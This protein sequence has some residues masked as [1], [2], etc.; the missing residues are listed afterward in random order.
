MGTSSPSARC[1]SRANRLGMRR[2]STWRRQRPSRPVY[3]QN[4]GGLPAWRVQARQRR[5]VQAWR[6]K[7]NNTWVGQTSQY[8]WAVY[9]L[10]ARPSRRTPGPPIKEMLW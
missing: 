10:T 9:S 4:W 6:L 7:A 1:F 3:R 2:R 8:S 5:A